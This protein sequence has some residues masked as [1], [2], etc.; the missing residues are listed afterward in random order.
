[1]NGD[2]G[3]VIAADPYPTIGNLDISQSRSHEHGI[4][5]P[6]DSAVGC[7]E[8]LAPV[9]D[10]QTFE[11]GQ[12]AYGVEILFG[13]LTLPLPRPST[14]CRVREKAVVSNDPA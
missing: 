11:G 2:Y 7:D 5:I 13:Q 8:H 1:M 10:S 3:P 9:T 14:V 6:T 12:K 4:D